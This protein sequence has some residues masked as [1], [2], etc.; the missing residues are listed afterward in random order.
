MSNLASKPDGTKSEMTS[1]QARSQEETPLPHDMAGA[2]NLMAHPMA[3]AA[4]MGALGLGMA[5]HVMGLWLGTVAGAAEATRR[6]V[7]DMEATQAKPAA[8]APAKLRVVATSDIP[9]RST[10]AVHTMLADAEI[11]VRETVDVVAHVMEDVAKDM[12]P[13]ATKNV[14][15][16]KAGPA[17]KVAPKAV[18]AETAVSAAAMARPAA[19]ERP[20][21]PDDLKALSGVGPKLEQVLNG[22]GIWTYAQ[23]AAL[24]EA[25][26]AWLDHELGFAGRIGRDDWLGQAGALAGGAR[27]E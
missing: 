23:I 27:V 1:N 12:L 7:E 21:R 26:I 24:S 22:F 9:D 18:A 6:M 16:K 13:K 14:D 4:A 3:G 8:K 25:E 2:V 15:V 17:R 20:A 11:A 10:A 5:S 19:I